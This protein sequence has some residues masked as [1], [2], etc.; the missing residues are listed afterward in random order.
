MPRWGSASARG[1]PRGAND[2]SVAALVAAVQDAPKFVIAA[3]ERVGLINEQRRPPLR[4]GT[5][6][7]CSRHI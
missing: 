1:R 5:E 6:E 4:D 2:E 7:S 3:K